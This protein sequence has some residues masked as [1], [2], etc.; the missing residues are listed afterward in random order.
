MKLEGP[1]VLDSQ[2]HDDQ[3]PDKNGYQLAGDANTVH[4]VVGEFIHHKDLID[5]EDAKN[6]VDQEHKATDKRLNVL[7]SE[8][9]TLFNEPKSIWSTRRFVL[10]V[11]VHFVLR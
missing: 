7:T 10:D 8:M 1:V 11:G 9:K 6:G 2:Q 4:T 5:E 3:Y